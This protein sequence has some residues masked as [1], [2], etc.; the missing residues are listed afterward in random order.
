MSETGY[1]VR[2]DL[3][4]SPA[5]PTVDD[6]VVAHD[7]GSLESGAAIPVDIILVDESYSTSPDHNNDADSDGES[8]MPTFAIPP[9][10]PSIKLP[11]SSPQTLTQ[12][13]LANLAVQ[14]PG[15]QHSELDT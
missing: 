15:Q 6:D 4:T 7:D 1:L 14:P 3:T 8:S 12:S 10:T 13:V 2:K 5:D 9:R 11:Q